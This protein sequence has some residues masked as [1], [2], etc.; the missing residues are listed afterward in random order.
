[1]TMR[2]WRPIVKK[3]EPMAKANKVAIPD[4]EY[5]EGKK[6]EGQV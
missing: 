4:D 1:M 2:G 5:H 6:D 3:A